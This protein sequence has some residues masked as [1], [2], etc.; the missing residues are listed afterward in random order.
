MHKPTVTPSITI[1]VQELAT[2]DFE[3][4]I[5]VRKLSSY[6]LSIEPPVVERENCF[7]SILLFTELHIHIPYQVISQIVTHIQFFYLSVLLLQLNEHILKESVVVLLLFLLTHQGECLES[8]VWVLGTCSRVLVQILHQD[9][10]TESR[11]V[12]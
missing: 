11:L 7:L 4:V 2:A 9:C 3:K 8:P 6:R 5:C 1:S 12:V 10:L